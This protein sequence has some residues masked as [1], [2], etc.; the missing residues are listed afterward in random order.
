MYVPREQ[1][2]ASARTT[3]AFKLLRPG[4]TSLAANTQPCPHRRRNASR[5]A[6]LSVCGADRLQQAGQLELGP[7]WGQQARHVVLSRPALGHGL[8]A[9]QSLHV[10]ELQ[11]FVELILA[12]LQRVVGLLQPRRKALALHKALHPAAAPRGVAGGGGV[13]V[14]VEEW[15]GGGGARAGGGYAARAAFALVGSTA[16]G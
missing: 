2:A 5:L 3:C 9:Q 12:A 16:R 8:R 13:C 11:G 1:K 6:H 14:C 15:G 7:V 10:E 4:P